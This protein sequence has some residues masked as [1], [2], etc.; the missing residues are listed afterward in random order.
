METKRKW[1]WN[2]PCTNTLDV[3]FLL[4]KEKHFMLTCMAAEDEERAQHEAANGN[5][6]NCP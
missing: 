1:L 2:N 5:S 6:P 4:E 3:A